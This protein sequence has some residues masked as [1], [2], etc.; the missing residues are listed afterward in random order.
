MSFLVT[1]ADDIAPR[2]LAV[3]WL[4]FSTR[5]SGQSTRADRWSVLLSQ[6]VS[7]V[8]TWHKKQDNPFCA[9]EIFPCFCALLFPK[10]LNL[11]TFS[12]FPPFLHIQLFYFS[13]P[14]LVSFAAGQAYILFFIN[15][16]IKNR[17]HA[18]VKKNASVASGNKMFYWQN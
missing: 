8:L 16:H 14:H 9:L 7:H 15:W 13:Y 10:Y 12:T 1:T 2:S 6:E 18:V 17:I 3:T 4:L 11:V 5:L